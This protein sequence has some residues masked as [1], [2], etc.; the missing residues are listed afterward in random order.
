MRNLLVV[1]IVAVAALLLFQPA[2][3]LAELLC[4]P[5][6]GQCGRYREVVD[7]TARMPPL[8]FLPTAP[9][10]TISFLPPDLVK[11]VSASP[12]ALI[13]PPGVGPSYYRTDPLGPVPSPSPTPHFKNPGDPKN[14]PNSPN[15][16][17]PN[18]GFNG[19]SLPD[20]RIHASFTYDGGGGPAD[21]GWNWSP[22]TCRLADPNNPLPG[23][24]E[25]SP[26]PTPAPVTCPC[27]TVRGQC[28]KC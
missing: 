13:S 9:A 11:R 16:C 2:T 22:G 19:Y 15:P 4:D 3:P 27:G 7:V 26:S 10:T 25:P 14:D 21:C 6:M 24:P 1:A 12:D 17:V 28:I 5:T 20:G 8:S 18:G 23:C